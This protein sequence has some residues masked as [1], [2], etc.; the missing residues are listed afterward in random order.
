MLAT[1]ILNRI[2]DHIE[3]QLRDE[4][5]GFRRGRSCID[6]SNTL[7]QIIE[8]SVEWNSPLYMVFIDF[9]R[10]FDTISQQAIWNALNT[11]GIPNKIINIIRAMYVESYFKVLHNGQ[12]GKPI[13]SMSGVKQG[14]PL[15]PLLFVTTLDE[16]M[17]KSASTPRG[18]R[19]GVCNRLE[20]LE[21]ADDI[22]LLSHT[23]QEMKEKL[24]DLQ[25]HA[26]EV[27]LYINTNKT[28]VMRIKTRNTEA[29]EIGNTI[30]EDVNSF[31]YLGSILSTDGGAA[32]DITSRIAKARGAFSSMWPVWKSSQISRNLKIKI[33]NAC[34]KSILLYGSETWLVR[35]SDMDKIQV[36][37]NKCIR[38][39]C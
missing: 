24:A 39:I 3:L 18:I 6:N 26:G 9:K 8:Q 27:G 16:V 19:W 29:F 5:A 28:K 2:A 33:F 38:I 30:I 12:L 20:A 11:K 34:I 32:A 1:I 31:N 25:K 14:C 4:Q 37:I 36:F 15:S 7:R 17:N 23:A 22:V 35:N 10:T 21:Y 13:K